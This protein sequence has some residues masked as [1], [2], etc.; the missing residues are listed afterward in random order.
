MK[1]YSLIL[2]GFSLFSCKTMNITEYRSEDTVTLS[3]DSDK[4]DTFDVY[5]SDT[6]LVP[7]VPCS[8]TNEMTI[9]NYPPGN[10]KFI[11]KSNG[12]V[13][14]TRKILIHN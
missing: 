6:L 13:V 12:D 2:I 5:S 10:Y 4:A 8:G 7:K 11:F 9:H 14:E 3:W 1:K